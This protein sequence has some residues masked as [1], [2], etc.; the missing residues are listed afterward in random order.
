MIVAYFISMPSTIDIHDL[1]VNRPE[2]EIFFT[3]DFREYGS[4]EAI[5]S[6]MHRFVKRGVLKRL[7]KGIYVKPGYSDLL[8]METLP[9]ME[10]LAQAIAR[11]DHAR[12]A[13]TGAMALYKLGLTTQIPLKLTYLTDGSAR[14]IKIGKSEITFKRVTPKKLVFK[15]QVSSL[16]VQALSEIGQSNLEADQESKIVE[17]L[18]KEKYEDLKHDIR[19]A[20]Q[21]IAEVMAKAL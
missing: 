18:R 21:W 7:A 17:Q 9:P 20:P 5:K 13:P 14:K 12:I 1:I 19:L 15:G 8:K 4:S 16:V 6:A 2:K 11:R 10:A 3:E